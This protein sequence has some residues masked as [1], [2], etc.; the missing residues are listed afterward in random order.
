MMLHRARP[1]H[2]RKASR[3]HRGVGRLLL[4]TAV[5]AVVGLIA[6][7]TVPGIDPSAA[8]S[9]ASLAGSQG[10]ATAL[11]A[12]VSAKTLSGQGPLE[13]GNG[14]YANLQVTVNQTQNLVNQA[15]SVS[16]T[17]G[18]QTTS[19][20]AFQADYLQIFE[21]WGDPQSTDPPDTT[22][23]G[24]LPTQCQFGAQTTTNSAYPVSDS[25]FEYTRV[26]SEPAWSTYSSTQGWTDNPGTNWKIQPFDAVDGTVVD[27]QADYNYAADGQSF[28]QNPYF[29]YGTSN[30]VDF[31]RTY[32][33][34][35]G[36]QL[37]QVQ[38]GLEA[39]GL[40]CG[41]DIEP[42]AGG[43]TTTP[44]CWLVVVPRGTPEEENPSGVVDPSVLTSPLTAAAWANRIAFPLG[45]NPIGTSCSINAV[46]QQ[47]DGDELAAAAVDS[48]QPS[49]CSLPGSPSYSYIENTDDQA[50][51]NIESPTYGSAG[52]SVFSDP[53][54]P[55]QVDPSDPV[56]YAP[57]TLSGVAVA[58]NIER[59]PS[60]D[61][62][63]TEVPLTGDQ[64]QNVYLTPRLMAK[65]LTQSYQA[66]FQNVTNDTSTCYDWAQAN[67]T[68]LL[69]DP[70]FLQW[71]PE[72]ADL[73]TTQATDASTALVEDLNSDAA[74]AIW[75]WILA[76][77]EARAWLSGTPDQ[78]GMKVN[79]IYN[80]SKP[81]PSSCTGGS[82]G[83]A[84]APTTPENYSKSDP[85]CNQTPYTVNGTGGG[86]PQ[87][88]RPLCIL[89]WSPYALNMNAAAQATGAANDGA[90]TTLNPAATPNTAWTANG[91]QTPGTNFIISITDTASAAQ[92]G[93]QTASLSRAGD[94]G[95]NRTFVAPDTAGLTAGEQALEPSDVS[96]VL[97][98]NP[99]TT[100]PG[101]YPL[102]ML[103]YAA[104]SP[105]TL[106]PSQRQ[107]YASFILYAIGDGQT[108]GVQPGELPAGYVPLPGPLRLEALDA[109]NAILNPPAGPA[110]GSS[111][112]S[113]T[114]GQHVAPV[115]S[116]TSTVAQTAGLPATGTGA[117]TSSS[118]PSTPTAAV[119]RLKPAAIGLVRTS[120][121]GVG[122][123]RWLLPLVLLI[124]LGAALG[125]VALDRLGRR[126]EVADAPT[127]D[128]PDGGSP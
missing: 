6:F 115:P 75:K 7:V 2:R 18:V 107:L 70:D 42:T 61:N 121:F 105:E 110:T 17:G 127:A 69:T 30:E 71:N 111:S 63:Q 46:A 83:A 51:Q 120:V 11:P 102:T 48:W 122:A 108:Q 62:G 33:G 8:A 3:T 112:T 37:F 81:A 73:S 9:P 68:N 84:F 10:I 94:D 104:T 16:W 39:P 12:T 56:V 28:W 55:S 32:A 64:V 19:S 126:P 97:Q 100:A 47:I 36:Q 29:R 92:Y 54:D 23:P 14:P 82:S 74:T 66:E 53:I 76:D 49:L 109:T 50:R 103:T 34:G 5:G 35:V 13:T 93:L 89:D 20:A 125:A 87:P 15:V 72:F 38:T 124:G 25:G 44:Q 117:T 26:L 113:P 79:P 101:A 86:P 45:F 43:G 96:G 57:L 116:A 4:G 59:V 60:V 78:W 99:S 31:S 80:I 128:P 77:P 106:T 65:L 67:P 21:C 95:P 91:P 24:P 85:Y 41:Q 27:R 40:G 119:R 114:S 52:M 118:I 1:V 90:K 123:I 58:F 98:E 22:D 88:A